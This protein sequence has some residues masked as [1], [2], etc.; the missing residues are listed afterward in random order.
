MKRIIL[1]AVILSAVCVLLS[2]DDTRRAKILNNE[3][4][5]D[6]TALYFVKTVAESGNKEIKASQVAEQISTNPRVK[7]FASMMISDHAKAAISL[8]TLA[9]HK[10]AT[11]PKG[12][13]EDDNNSVKSLSQ[14]SGAG[15]DKQYMQ[16][17]VNDHMKAV[18]LFEEHQITNSVPAGDF[19]RKTLPT[20]EM[21]LDSAKAIL[22]SLK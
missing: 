13:S 4:Q 7:G 15:F 16:M 10:F 14:L 19:A 5:L 3:T 11:L 1:P 22:A 9:A 18:G 6:Q 8:D 2:C 20:I 12:L 21:H 17:M